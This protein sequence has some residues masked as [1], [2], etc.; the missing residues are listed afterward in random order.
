MISRWNRAVALVT[1]LLGGVI[2]LIL[3]SHLFSLWRSFKWDTESE[4]E[5][6]VDIWAVNGLGIIGGL[7]AAY[8][9]TAA[10]AN[11]VGFVGIAK[12]MPR[13]VRFYR[14][15]SIADFVCSTLATLFVTYAS[16]RYYNI[17]T[18]VCEEVSRHEELMMDMA[19]IGLNLEN[20]EQWFERAL[21]AFVA[22]MII[23]TAVR[24]HFVIT[25][26]KIFAKMSQYP[27]DM[28]SPSPR[29]HKDSNLQRIYIL[30]GPSGSPKMATGGSA[31]ALPSV[32]YAPI[33]LSQLSEREVR[34]LQAHEAWISAEA[35]APLRHMTPPRPH[36]HHNSGKIGLPIR[37]DEGLLPMHEKEKMPR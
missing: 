35:Q 24:L 3:A 6:S 10:I 17:R 1:S 2:N 30:P 12:R 20:C 9:L 22:V 37:P 7:F 27:A 28:P 5:G 33:P 23:V 11:G 4:W 29:P 25:I 32:V 14:D 18:A 15:F 36:R 34:Q 31:Q 21:F 8:F 13:Y 16:C 26:S 19:E